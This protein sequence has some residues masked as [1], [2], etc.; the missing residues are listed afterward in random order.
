MIG[1]T[2]ELKRGPR[3]IVVFEVG[4]SSARPFLC[5]ECRFAYHSKYIGSSVGICSCID[6]DQENKPNI[7]CTT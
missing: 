7:E 1:L 5:L 4:R 2:Q 3:S 6:N